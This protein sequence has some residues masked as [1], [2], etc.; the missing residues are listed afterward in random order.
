MLSKGYNL[1][2]YVVGRIG[3][4]ESR[5]VIAKSCKTLGRGE[6]LLG[7]LEQSVGLGIGDHDGSPLILKSERILSLVVLTD[8]GRRDENGRLAKQCQFGNR[9]CAGA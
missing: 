3:A 4:G 7:C 6:S 5:D 8:V 2:R 9:A 1:S